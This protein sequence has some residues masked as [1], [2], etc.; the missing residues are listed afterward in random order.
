[1]RAEKYDQCTRSFRS[2]ALFTLWLYHSF[3]FSSVVDYFTDIAINSHSRSG[4]PPVRGEHP[5]KMPFARVGAMPQLAASSSQSSNNGRSSRSRSK[6]ITMEVSGGRSTTTVR[7]SQSFIMEILFFS[8][9]IAGN[10][11]Y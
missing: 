2:S 7:A 5:I 6:G 1:M 4:Q 10:D 8:R 3:H 11:F 9:V